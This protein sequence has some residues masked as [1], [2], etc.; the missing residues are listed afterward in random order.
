[1]YPIVFTDA[2]QLRI[3][4]GGAL[5]I[6]ACH[7]AARVNVDG[8]E[9]VLGMWIEQNEGTRFQMQMMTEFRNRGI[10]DV[11]IVACN[12]LPG[13]PEAIASVWPQ[14]VV[15]TCVVH[16]IR[17]SM[18]YASWKDRKAIRLPEAI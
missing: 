2:I 14:A 18:R 6:K 13:L 10:K 5:R 1:M 3:R 16:L 9:Q 4:D 7:L 8:I 17:N 15:Q 11:R 12:G